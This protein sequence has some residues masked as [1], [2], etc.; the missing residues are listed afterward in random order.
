MKENMKN[1]DIGALFSRFQD[2]WDVLEP[3]EGH[4]QRFA[5]R[6]EKKTGERLKRRILWL[7]PAAAVVLLGLFVLLPVQSGTQ[8]SPVLL[9]AESRQA[10]S[11]FTANIRLG[12][13]LLRD[14]ASGADRQ[15]VRD[16]LE[17]LSEMEKDYLKI[18]DDLRKN[19]ESRQLMHALM[20]NLRTQLEFL[21]RVNQQL[22]DQSHQNQSFEN[23]HVI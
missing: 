8:Q 23:E 4:Q 2:Q 21:E 12:K 13:E 17:Q 11:V 22:E 5:S 10:D 18:K 15:L 3:A 14:N 16:A 7:L 9:S 19:G 1:D 20:Q 6:L